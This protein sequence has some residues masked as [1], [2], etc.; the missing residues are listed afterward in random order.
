M[1]CTYKDHHRAIAVYGIWCW[2]RGWLF[3]ARHP[4]N[5]FCF[6]IWSREI[7]TEHFSEL[8]SII[9]WDFQIPNRHSRMLQLDTDLCNN[10]SITDDGFII[11]PLRGVKLRKFLRSGCHLWAGHSWPAPY[12]G[13]AV[14]GRSFITIQ[15]Y[16]LA[17]TLFSKTPRD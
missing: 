3:P 9:F 2:Q 15:Y 11:F 7:V 8:F 16:L 6:H 14:S 4:L 1:N 10:L 17:I 12:L 13:L 5:T